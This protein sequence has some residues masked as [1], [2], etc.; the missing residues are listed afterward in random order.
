VLVNSGA[1][2]GARSRPF[3]TAQASCHGDTT[4]T[5]PRRR[6][7]AA[8]QPPITSTASANTL[9]WLANAPASGSSC[10]SNPVNATRTRSALPANA[11]NQP[12][13]VDTGRPN[14][15]AIGRCPQPPAFIRTAAP[16]TSTPSARRSRHE[17]TSSTCV[18]RQLRQRARRGA[19]PPTPR[20]VR[21]RA[22]PHGARSPPHG[23]ASSPA[24]SRRSTSTASLPTMTTGASKHQGT[25]L[26][27]GQGTGRA[28]AH[29][30]R[31]Q[32]AVAHEQRATRR[33]P[34]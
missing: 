34:L 8:A 4:P 15:A 28:V 2:R 10:T 9:E 31:D 22:R 25:A 16:I 26:P 23:H 13:T 20:T 3:V 24:R 17:T 7:A 14:R 11:R 12:R 19:N 6:R 5:T 32:V 27:S 33:Q 1:G 30:E 21:T 29:P 18:T